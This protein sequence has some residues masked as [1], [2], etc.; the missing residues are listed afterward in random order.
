M[1]AAGCSV[2]KPLATEGVRMNQ[3]GRKFINIAKEL[4]HVDASNDRQIDRQIDLKENFTFYS[5]E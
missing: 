4:E 3:P 1:S 5:N 2:S